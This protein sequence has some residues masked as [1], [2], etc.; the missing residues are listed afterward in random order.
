MEYTAS[1]S[2]TMRVSSTATMDLSITVAVVEELIRLAESTTAVNVF[3]RSETETTGLADTLAKAYAA[4]PIVNEVLAL[5]RSVATQYFGRPVLSE[6]V[7]LLDNLVAGQNARVSDTMTIADTVALVAGVRIL[8]QLGI[9]PSALGKATYGLSARESFRFQDFLT[10]FFGMDVSETLGVSEVL[11]NKKNILR[12]ISETVGV[13][14]TLSRRLIFRVDT[15][16]G[17][18]LDDNELI[19]M[20]FGPTINDVVGVSA[21]YL[22]PSGSITTWAVNTRSGATTE[23]TNYNFNSF[24]RMGLRYFGASAEGLYE[25]DGDTDDG[26]NIIAKIKSG[27]AQFGGSRYSSFKAAYVGMRGDGY[28]YLKLTTGDGKDYTY[29]SM[30]QNMQTTKVLLGKGLRARYFSFELVSDGQDFDL[31]TIEFIP[32]VA[33]RRV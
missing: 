11:L 22:E 17:L 12:N 16:E 10:R 21:A 1:V 15:R 26:E 9:T 5:R 31:D 14:E 6:V 28:I 4:G 23:Y 30:L 2:D 19:K 33:N 20:L 24:A 29:R 32:L 13:T 27:F 25:L 3:T 18:A 7:R 8:E